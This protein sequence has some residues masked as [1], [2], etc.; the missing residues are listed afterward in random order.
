MSAW[1]SSESRPA[2][3]AAPSDG[4]TCKALN[5]A[6]TRTGHRTR[7]R[8]GA[9]RERR[10]VN[11]ADDM[12]QT[13]S[14]HRVPAVQMNPSRRTSSRVKA[15]TEPCL[16]LLRPPTHSLAYTPPPTPRYARRTSGAM[17]SG[18]EVFLRL[19]RKSCH[20]HVNVDGR[21]GL[22]P[23]N[24]ELPP[25]VEPA[26]HRTFHFEMWDFVVNRRRVG[27][28]VQAFQRTPVPRPRTLAC[29]MQLPEERHD[30]APVPEGRHRDSR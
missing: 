4:M 21:S 17:P 6:L 19:W 29:P 26:S 23:V 18:C 2:G 3:A 14:S 1:C 20:G 24:D 11:R 28:G 13:E 16:R 5:S 30:T 10:E 9:G 7:R 15:T 27:S 12:S 25:F 22:D 8:Q